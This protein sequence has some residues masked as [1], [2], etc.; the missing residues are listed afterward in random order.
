MEA[1]YHRSAHEKYRRIREFAMRRPHGP[2]EVVHFVA[3]IR[4]AIRRALSAVGDIQGSPSEATLIVCEDS[5]TMF[6]AQCGMHVGVPTAM[7][8]G[9]MNEDEDSD[10]FRWRAVCSRVEVGAARANQPCL[11]ARSSHVGK[12]GCL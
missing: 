2:V 5:N 7:L 6:C 11:D 10:G 1:K 12:L 3:P 8:R 9:A 4:F